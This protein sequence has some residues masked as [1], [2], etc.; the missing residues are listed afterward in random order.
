MAVTLTFYDERDDE[1]SLQLKEDGENLS[2]SAYGD[3]TKVELLCRAP[4]GTI[5]TLAS[6]NA[7]H[8][9]VIDAA[10]Q[11]IVLELGLAD[12]LPVGM[13]WA[14]VVGYTSADPAGLVFAD[15]SEVRI[16]KKA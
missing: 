11:Q 6:D 14:R 10:N 8:K 16:I 9:I 3:L 15:H 2:V 12:A 4:D 13:Y 7:D 1:R 5:T